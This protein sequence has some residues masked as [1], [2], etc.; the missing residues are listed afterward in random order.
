MNEFFGYLLVHF[1]EDPLNHMEK[2]F[3]SL[4]EG[5]SPLTWR[6]LN[7]GE[8]V[9]ESCGGTGGVRDPN[10]I[11][12]PQ[13]VFYLL[14]T[15][16]RVWGPTGPNWWEFR[17][18][19]SRDLVIWESTDLLSW[20]EPRYITVAPEG[21]GMAWAPKAV[22]DPI[23]GDY[24]VLFSTGLAASWPHQQDPGTEAE[25]GASRIMMTRTRDFILFT[26]AESYLE[27]PVGVIDMSVLVTATSVHRFAKH[28]DGAPDSLHVFQQRGSALF[29]D[30]FLTV[31]HGIGQEIAPAV[32]GPLAFRDNRE[33]RWYLWVDQYSCS[34]QGYEAYTTTDIDAGDWHRVPEFRLPENTKHGTVMPLHQA[35]YEAL[36]ALYPR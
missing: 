3:L 23:S 4:S 16:L 15:D 36:D 9:L 24:V 34:P 18:R 12:G 11:R 31:S 26:P 1:V 35:E 33:S 29:A 14:A 6:R 21:A 25:T 17:H 2:I 7:H 13:G 28:D 8:P 19:G 30:D 20:S 10:I 5:D 32:E 27:Q 22:Y